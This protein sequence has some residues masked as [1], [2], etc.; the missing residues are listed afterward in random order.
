MNFHHWKTRILLLIFF[1]LLIC[2]IS[3]PIW[4]FGA[5]VI[6]DRAN[7]DYVCQ[8]MQIHW[9]GAKQSMEILDNSSEF[10]F[11]NKL[12]RV[13]SF[14]DIYTDGTSV[15]VVGSFNEY[16]PPN[17]MNIDIETGKLNWYACETESMILGEN[18]L[19]IGYTDFSGAFVTA[20]EVESGI[21]V[22]YTKV[23]NHGVSDIE[24][25]PIGLLVTTNNHGRERYY[26][27]NKNDGQQ[28]K[29]FSDRYA[30]NEFFI[31]NG[32]NIFKLTAEGI[33]SSGDQ[34]WETKLN[35]L[36][37]RAKIK[38]TSRNGVVLVDIRDHFLSRVI[39]L[40]SRTGAILWQTD[41]NIKSD[42]AIEDNIVYFLTDDASLLAADLTTGYILGHVMFSPSLKE[43]EEFDFVNAYPR[44]SVN[45]GVVVVYFDN[46]RQLFTFQFSLSK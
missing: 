32:Q 46:S 8:P 19:Y 16:E 14:G 43:M 23:D 2:F 17:L 27:L 6:F 35:E 21:E 37:Y 40:D 42:L 34:N 3:V 20:Y 44:I 39:A 33:A 11:I 25:T 30:M 38:T 10:E 5:V 29:S 7:S 41:Q 12:Q 26:L 31:Q 22:W 45:N 1:L 18:H 4:G 28:S 15:T 24:I 9:E 36:P 13:Y